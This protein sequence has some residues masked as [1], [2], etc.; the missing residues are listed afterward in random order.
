MKCVLANNKQQ[1]AILRNNVLSVLS[2]VHG[3]RFI[4]S[5][6][7][8]IVILVPRKCLYSAQA[9]VRNS[10]FQSNFY[11]FRRGHGFCP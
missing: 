9:R 10:N 5:Q 8:K 1:T 7:N 6:S 3:V 2:E 11:N 4:E